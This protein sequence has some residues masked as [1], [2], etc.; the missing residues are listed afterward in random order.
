MMDVALLPAFVAVAECG[1]FT[2]AAMRLGVT[3]STVSQQIRRLETGLDI[4]LF[5]RD[6]HNVGLTAAGQT[7]LSSARKLLASITE[8]EMQ[9]RSPD[10]LGH[11]RLGIAEDLASTRLPYILRQFRQ[12]HRKV[13]I[14]VDVDMSRKLLDRLEQGHLDL[15]L[16]K[17]REEDRRPEPRLLSEPLCWVGLEER[18]AIA[19]ERPLPLALH[20]EPSVTRRFVLDRLAAAAIEADVVH[21]SS[22][23]LGLQAG[24]LAGIGIGALGRSFVPPEL[25]ILDREALGLPALPALDFILARRPDPGEATLILGELI[26]KNVRS[27]QLM[28]DP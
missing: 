3:Q 10:M 15:A 27:L 20:P 17:C 28:R 11:V 6:T 24:V 12:A 13:R 8:T 4:I 19:R 22:N 21:S 5:D 7:L 1:S 18:P 16:V 25:R 26:E 9:L 14:S 23:L 2:Q